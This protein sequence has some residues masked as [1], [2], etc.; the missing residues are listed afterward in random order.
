MLFFFHKMLNQASKE[1]YYPFEKNLLLFQRAKEN[2]ETGSTLLQNMVSQEYFSLFLKYPKEFLFQLIHITLFLCM[3]LICRH[4]PIHKSRFGYYQGTEYTD[5][6]KNEIEKVCR[7]LE[8]ESSFFAEFLKNNKDL[9]RK[10][11]LNIPWDASLLEFALAKYFS[12]RHAI[13][14]ILSTILYHQVISK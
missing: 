8:I 14:R 4:S 3:P 10:F 2:G 6:S 5:S 13:L 1:F 7:S 11:D 12:E 9:T